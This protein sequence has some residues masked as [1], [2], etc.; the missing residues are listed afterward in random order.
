MALH[1]KPIGGQIIRT[2]APD[3]DAR[4]QN[5]GSSSLAPGKGGPLTALG[6]NLRDSIDDPA[7]DKILAQ[8]SAGRGDEIPADDTELATLRSFD[9]EDLPAG[10]ELQRRKVSDAS[11]PVAHGQ[12]RQ[13][14][15]DAVFGNV[16]A[17]PQRVAKRLSANGMK[18]LA[19][20]T[21]RAAVAR[22]P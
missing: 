1:K 20:G 17:R 14:N 8:G 7:R 12:V 15:P 16:A 19:R 6:R 21:A 5:Y 10:G 13:Q 3:E 2:P 11:Y 4:V 18:A 9:A 22:K